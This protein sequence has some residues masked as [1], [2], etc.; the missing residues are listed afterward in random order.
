M[1]MPST[2]PGQEMRVGGLRCWFV[3]SLEA[4]ANDNERDPL[5]VV[6]EEERAITQE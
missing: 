4:R 2:I 3:G 1:P 6:K 5:F